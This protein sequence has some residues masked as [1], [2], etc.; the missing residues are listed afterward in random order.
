MISE[1]APV[2]EDA[3]AEIGSPTL[4]PEAVVADEAPRVFSSAG[5]DADSE[6]LNDEDFDYEFDDDFEDEEEDN[7]F[8]ENEITEEEILKG[9]PIPNSTGDDDSGEGATKESGDS[10]SPE[11]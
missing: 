5:E 10:D 8:T 2:I 6:S 3:P 9:G 4:L 1:T 11:K 7:L